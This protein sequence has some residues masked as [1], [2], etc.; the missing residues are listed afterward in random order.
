MILETKEREKKTRI[1]RNFS[2]TDSVFNHFG[3]LEDG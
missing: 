3:K 1:M 2:R